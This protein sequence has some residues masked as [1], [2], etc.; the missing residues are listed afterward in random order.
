LRT[1]VRAVIT[2]LL[3]I[4][5]APSGYSQSEPPKSTQGTLTLDEY[6]NFVD[7]SRVAIA[8]DGQSVVIAT[9]RPDW[10]QQRYR[11][12]LWIWREGMSSPQL[13]TN[14]GHDSMPKWSPDGKWIAFVSDRTSP[15]SAADEDENVPKE[16]PVVTPPKARE[17]DADEKKESSAQIYIISTAGGEAVPVTRGIEEVHAFAWAP[18][19]S[20]IFFATRTPWSKAKRDAY[21]KEWKDVIRFRES[22]RGDVIARIAIRDALARVAGIAQSTQ[23]P[24]LKKPTETAET[25]GSILICSIPHRV[26][27]LAVSPDG[28]SLAFNTDSVSQRVEGIGSYEIFLVPAS[29][30]QPRQLT[31]NQAIES[32]LRWAPD[33]K[34]ILFEVGMG[35][36][37]HQYEDVQKRLYSV[38]VDSGATH[39]WAGEFGGAIED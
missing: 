17:G 37:E 14:S 31:H 9:D 16:P 32:R 29:G 11:E 22:E 26:S 27:D 1:I 20:S 25:P 21:K 6:F 13:L 28:K 30:G 35:S 39:R 18:D 2:L 15:A 38:D 3:P 12:D 10:N 24:E 4:L 7:Y 36:V 5:M 23:Q 19:S 34:S 33:G 8:P